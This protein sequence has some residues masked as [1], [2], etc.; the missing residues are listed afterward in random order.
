M[1][2]LAFNTHIDG[3]R[4]FHDEPKKPKQMIFSV[5]SGHP[6]IKDVGDL[7]GVIEREKAAM[8]RSLLFASQQ[9]PCSRKGRRLRR[10]PPLSPL[11]E[12]EG[13]SRELPSWLR[14]GSGR[15]LKTKS[16]WL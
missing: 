9:N 11:L 1:V 4:Y 12:E 10:P 13:N 15:G 8:A 3:R 6:T 5:K 2:C 14:R 7:R 16:S